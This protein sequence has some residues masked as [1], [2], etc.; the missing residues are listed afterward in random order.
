MHRT[1]YEFPKRMKVLEDRA[2]GIVV[3]RSAVMNVSRQPHGI[4]DVLV[5]DVLEQSAISNS[6]PSAGPSPLAQFSKSVFPSPTMMPIGISL[7]MTFH[8]A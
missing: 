8:V 6:R 4:L 5:F 7:Q 2:I 3:M 1:A